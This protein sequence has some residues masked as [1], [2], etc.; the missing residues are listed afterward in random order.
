MTAKTEIKRNSCKCYWLR[1]Y[2]YFLHFKL[3]DSHCWIKTTYCCTSTVW[4]MCTLSGKIS[5]CQLS[6]C[7]VQVPTATLLPQQLVPAWVQYL[8][9]T[10][11]AA[12]FS[13]CLK[14]FSGLL[15]RCSSL[16]LSLFL[17]YISSSSDCYL[18]VWVFVFVSVLTS[19]SVPVTAHKVFYEPATRDSS[20]ASLAAPCA[21]RLQTQSN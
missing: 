2:Y 5:S 10:L 17:E 8:T 9:L 1:Y 21:A 3:C 6:H 18:S 16:L 7:R 4:Y 14:L 19:S 12:R 11:G 20:H 13:F 15:T